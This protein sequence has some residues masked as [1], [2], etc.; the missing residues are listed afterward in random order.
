MM[1]AHGLA[2]AMTFFIAGVLSDRGGHQDLARWGGLASTMP[3]FWN[4]SAVAFCATLGIPGLCGFVG[5]ILILLG[6]FQALRPDALLFATGIAFR[7]KIFTLAI[8]AVCGMVLT[9]GYVTVAL[10]RI[11]FGP[12]RPEQKNFSEI[13][14]RE[15]AVLVILAGAAILL[16]VLPNVLMFSMTGKTIDAMFGLFDNAAS[17]AHAPSDVKPSR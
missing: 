12:E 17:A 5:E 14:Q 10:Q 9:V 11:F 4:L 13:D 1:I 8:L 15:T 3:R 7:G 16:G 6:L 2:S